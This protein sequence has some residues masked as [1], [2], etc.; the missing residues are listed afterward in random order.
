[1][2]RD[3]VILPRHAGRRGQKVGSA[4]NIF[5]VLFLKIILKKD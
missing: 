4:N 1:M 5:E 3:N 2:G